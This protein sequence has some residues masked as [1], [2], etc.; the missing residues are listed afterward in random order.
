M[1]MR[2]ASYV[3]CV[4]Q[5]TCKIGINT[6]ISCV[7]QDVAREFEVQAMPTFLLMKKGSVVDKVVGAK[8]D[9]LERKITQHRSS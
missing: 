8:K 6:R 3:L 4:L 7:L 2:Y 5:K 1:L 9:E